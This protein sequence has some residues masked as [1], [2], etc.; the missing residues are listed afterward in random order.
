MSKFVYVPTRKGQ[1]LGSLKLVSA[2]NFIG[3]GSFEQAYTY[4]DN[5]DECLED[6]H[7]CSE[8]ADCENT[9]GGFNCKC[10]KGY[11]GDGVTCKR[12]KIIII[13]MP[14]EQYNALRINS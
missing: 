10:F 1:S 7:N 6:K 14:T 2:S 4:I 11:E 12:K 5:I 13:I 3:L 9:L 8:Y